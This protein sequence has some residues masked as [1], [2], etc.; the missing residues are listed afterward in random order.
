MIMM[1]VNVTYLKVFDQIKHNLKM[2]CRVQ[3][4]PHASGGI[5]DHLTGTTH[6]TDASAAAAIINIFFLSL[7]P[8]SSSSIVHVTIEG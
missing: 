7:F 8:S 5:G 3:S 6:T 2:F 4:K 1:A